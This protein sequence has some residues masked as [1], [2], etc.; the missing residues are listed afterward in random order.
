[1]PSSERMQAATRRLI[2]W[3]TVHAFFLCAEIAPLL[4]AVRP[5]D[6]RAATIVPW[7]TVNRCNV[8]LVAI[9]ELTMIY[10]A[11]RVGRQ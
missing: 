5:V 11:V 8:L 4:V 6:V 9:A 1:M 7:S 3:C 10:L 2:T